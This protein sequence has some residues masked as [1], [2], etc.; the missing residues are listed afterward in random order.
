ML[1]CII[2]HKYNPCFHFQSVFPTPVA[3]SIIA[4]PANETKMVFKVVLL[5]QYGH[6]S[7]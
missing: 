3:K 7:K 6:G 2:E 4:L 5:K 1:A